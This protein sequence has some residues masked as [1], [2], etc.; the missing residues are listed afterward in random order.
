MRFTHPRVFNTVVILFLSAVLGGVMFGQSRS[1]PKP[2]STEDQAALVLFTKLLDTVEENYA[3]PVDADKAIY[4]SIDGMLRTL[5]PHSRFFDPKA[6]VSLQEDQTGRYFGLGI[7]ITARFGKVTVISPPFKGSPAEKVGLRVGDVISQVEGNP[8]GID[9]NAVV[10]RL[11]GP[12]G[13]P[14]HI[15]VV[16]PGVDAPIPLTVIRDAISKYT[17]NNF[18]MIRPGIG[19]IKLDSFAETS[20]NELR[21][22]LKELD[23]K[24]L[25]GMIFDLRGNPGGL[26]TQAIQVGETFLQRDQLI[27][28]TVG[29]TPG[30]SKNYPSQ[31]TNVDNTYPMVVL[32]N[33]GSASASEIVSGALQD[34]DRALIVGEVS[35]GKGLVQ[36]VYRLGNKGE[37][38]L[39]LT[40]QK[41]LT[42]SGRLIQRDYSQI[43][44]F[45]YLYHRDTPVNPATNPDTKF[46]DI[47]RPLY[48]GG[49]ITPDHLVSIPKATEFQNLMANKF[50][51][52]DYIWSPTTKFLANNPTIAPSFQVTDAMLSDFKK[53]LQARGIAFSDSDFESNKDYLKRMIK[54]EV[55]TDRVGTAEGLRVLLDADPQVLA[56]LS[57]MPEAKSLNQNKTRRQ[58]AQR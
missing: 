44:Q 24:H 32:V 27:L 20:G 28:K 53:R 18:Y 13:T 12:Q 47:G 39:A 17:I 19:Y 9:V 3:T 58:V 34:H 46:S 49:G 11:K 30:S 15:T 54:Y 16:R 41:W 40:T 36:S 14:V 51:Y 38:G 42:P 29:R 8:T 56:A 23:V 6:W 45:D 21:A 25:D 48:G 22:A 5:D 1:T 2:S 33:Q 50:A 35:F 55:L 52:Y 4:G 10:G 57:F 7:M 26:L 43:S 37:T 31:Q